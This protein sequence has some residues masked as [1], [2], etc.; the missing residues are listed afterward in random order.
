MSTPSDD[1][2]TEMPAP[3]GRETAKYLDDKAAES[4]KRQIDLEESVWRSLP[5]FTGALIAAAALIAKAASTLPPITCA[6]FPIITYAVLGLAVIFFA[7]AFW[8]LWQ[9]VRP[10]EY[11]FP[12]DD[13][14]IV[15]YAVNLSSFYNSLDMKKEDIDGAVLSDLRSYVTQTLGKAAKSTFNNNQA[16]LSARSQVLVWLLWGFVLS[17][18]AEAVIYVHSVAA[19]SQKDKVDSHGDEARRIRSPIKTEPA[20]NPSSSSTSAHEGDSRRRLVDKN[21][22]SGSNPGKQK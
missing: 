10:R 6:P 21:K 12:A 16:R 15:N 3:L 8:W 11:D 20:S 17:F 22:Y 9:I 1:L 19:A 2:V 4:F 18:S 13:A 7:V 14:E 5:L